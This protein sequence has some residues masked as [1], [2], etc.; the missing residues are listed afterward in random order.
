MIQR[1]GFGHESKFDVVTW[2]FEEK[3]SLLS[4]CELL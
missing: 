4:I 2:E 3:V 1:K